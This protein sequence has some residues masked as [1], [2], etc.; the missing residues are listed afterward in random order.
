VPVG[1]LHGELGFSDAAESVQGLGEHGRHRARF[2][3]FVQLSQ[4]VLAAGEVRVARRN[5]TPDG[6]RHP[7]PGRPLFHSR[8]GHGGHFASCFWSSTVDL[9]VRYRRRFPGDRG[10]VNQRCGWHVRQRR[11]RRGSRPADQVTVRQL[12]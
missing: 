11:A 10:A 9:R 8:I 3:A 2:Q 5:A 1:V 12:L 4:Q 7:G 6:G